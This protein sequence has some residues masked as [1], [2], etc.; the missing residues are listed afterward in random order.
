MLLTL[1]FRLEKLLISGL[2]NQYCYVNYDLVIF[3]EQRGDSTAVPLLCYYLNYGLDNRGE[4]S[5]LIGVGPKRN[6][7]LVLEVVL[8]LLFK[9]RSP[10]ISFGDANTHRVLTRPT[11]LSKQQ[12]RHS[13]PSLNSWSAFHFE[14]FNA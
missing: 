10:G 5:R 4:I 2:G 6:R 12:K 9:L 13:Q 1:I 7:F 8:V 3:N 14:E 11:K